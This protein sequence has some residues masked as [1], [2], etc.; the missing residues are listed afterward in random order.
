MENWLFCR[1]FDAVCILKC[2]IELVVPQNCSTLLFFPGG[3]ITTFV[4]TTG[5]INID[6]NISAIQSLISG[7]KSVHKTIKL[8]ISGYISTL[9]CYTRSLAQL[10]WIVSITAYSVYVIVF[11]KLKLSSRRLV[12]SY[13]KNNRWDKYRGL[14]WWFENTLKKWKLDWRTKRDKNTDNDSFRIA[15]STPNAY[16]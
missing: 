13:K 16:I 15:T 5:T 7:Y 8:I 14:S 12:I 10:I 11:S 1:I 9:L 4:G 2:K 3:G 6:V